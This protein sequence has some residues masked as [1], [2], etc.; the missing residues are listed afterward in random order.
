[1]CTG[2][3]KIALIP[4]INSVLIVLDKN[5]LSLVF[6]LDFFFTNLKKGKRLMTLTEFHCILKTTCLKKNVA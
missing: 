4:N 2:L 1:M 6:I 5:S 3:R